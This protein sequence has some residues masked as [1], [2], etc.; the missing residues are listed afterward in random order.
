MDLNL[1]EWIAKIL[2]ESGPQFLRGTGMTVFLA[3]IGTGIGFVIGLIIGVIRTIPKN[4]SGK[5]GATPR[6]VILSA[7]NAVM[8]VYV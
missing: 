2:R 4:P 8:A 7:V 3:V 6:S 1:F 5:G